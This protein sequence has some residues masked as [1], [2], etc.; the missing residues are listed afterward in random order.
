[1]GE[2]WEDEAEDWVRW[3][4]T[5]GHD[6]YWYYSP[7]FF[8]EIVP[9]P[10]RRTL[11]LG[12]GEGRV[13]RD[14]KARGHTVVGIDSSPTLLEHA[15][16]ADP[17][18]EYVLVDA[19]SLPFPDGSFDLV[20]AHNSLMD[21]DNLPAAVGEAGRVLEGGGRMAICVTHPI[22]DAGAFRERR[23][24]AE[25]V[26]EGSYR[27]RQPFD[28]RFERD[29]L[30]MRFHGWTLP[31]EAYARALEQAGLAIERIRE[32]GAPAAL[33]ERDP[34]IARWSRVPM[35]MWLRAFKPV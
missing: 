15:R 25:F 22:N 24:D 34:E 18:G 3:A 6:A 27:D 1:M 28:M 29:G 30:E 13:V 19:A 10:G 5:P 16:T 4:R 35:F 11:E 7:G 2:T 33:V 12:C 9:G 23:A 14:L 20:V 21:I 8:E 31:L 26:I 17:E 32:P